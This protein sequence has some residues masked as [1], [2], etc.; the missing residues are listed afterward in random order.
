MHKKDKITEWN[1]RKF[2]KI[3]TKNDLKE[4]YKIGWKL[5]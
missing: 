3:G 4:G 2:N 1:S 5:T